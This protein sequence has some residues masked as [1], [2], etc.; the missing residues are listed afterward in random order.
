MTTQRQNPFDLSPLA[1][2]LPQFQPPTPSFVDIIVLSWNIRGKS[3]C[4]ALP[5]NL[6]VHHVVSDINP[7]V[8]LLQEVPSDMIINDLI[9]PWCEVKN[10]IY[11]CV[12]AGDKGEARVLYDS[13]MFEP[14][15]TEVSSKVDLDP[16]VAEVVLPMPNED[17]IM[18][19]QRLQAEQRMY[20]ERVAAVRL[21]HKATGKIIIFMSFHNKY[22]SG[23]VQEMATKFCRMVHRAARMQENALVVAGADLN[24]TDFSCHGVHIPEYVPTNRRHRVIDYYV[25]AWPDNIWVEDLIVSAHNIFENDFVCQHIERLQDIVPYSFQDYINSLDHDPLV[26]RLRVVS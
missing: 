18:Y 3:G 16:L 25:S 19:E 10:R 11:H 12:S 13:C 6:L 9:V 21:K 22:K 14:Y 8:I 17:E 7:D 23:K 26:Y 5:R 2:A 20:G 15:P 4:K 1:S 24:C